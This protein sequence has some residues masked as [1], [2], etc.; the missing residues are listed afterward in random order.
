V[1][2][3]VSFMAILI[4]NRC[5]QHPAIGPLP[6]CSAR[7]GACWRRRDASERDPRRLR[8]SDRPSLRALRRSDA[9]TCSQPASVSSAR[10]IASTWPRRRRTRASSL[11]FSRMVCVM[12][13]LSHTPLPYSRPTQ[14]G[15][16]RRRA[17][18]GTGR[19]AC[20]WYGRGPY[21]GGY[22]GPS[23]RPYGALGTEGRERGTVAATAGAPAR[24]APVIPS[25]RTLP[26]G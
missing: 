5:E 8:P 12:G 18:S 10:S 14:F 2:P 19:G 17:I 4:S 23:R 22:C 9:I 21:P 26:G 24:A 11:V 16:R 15:R 3:F 25:A 20:H 6:Q 1:P 13:D 7:A